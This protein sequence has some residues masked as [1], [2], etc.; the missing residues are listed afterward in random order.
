MR[1]FIWALLASCAWACTD[2]ATG[3]PVA[4]EMAGNKILLPARVGNS[5]PL[6]FILDTGAPAIMIDNSRI[7]SLG[8]HGE[9]REGRGGAGGAPVA[10]SRLSPAT[11]I[12][13]GGTELNTEPLAIDLSAPTR[14]DG[15]RVDGLIGGEFFQRYIVEIDYEARRIRILDGNFQY[16]G[17]GAVLPISRRRRPHVCNRFCQ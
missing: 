5:Q 9:S 13:V 8:F 12:N 17:S 4:F 16:N 1:C 3:V 15:L 7:E 11:C 10:I 14:A 2:R 6:R